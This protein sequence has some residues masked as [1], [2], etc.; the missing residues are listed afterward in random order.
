MQY[1]HTLRFRVFISYTILGCLISLFT[2]VFILL[3]IEALERQFMDSVLIEELNYFIERSDKDPSITQQKSKNWVIYKVENKKIPPNMAFLSDYPAGNYDIEY[4][5]QLYDLGVINRENIFYYILYNDDQFEKLEHKI[6]I[7][8][9]AGCFIILSLTTW[10]G[11]SL[12]KKVLDPIITL[13]SE[14]KKM[15]PNNTSNYLAPNYANDEVGILALE[16]DAFHDRLQSL[17][18]R[19]REFTG[20]ASH[21]LRTPLAVISAA[22]EN[23][24]LQ[25]DL[26]D[27]VQQ[28][29]SRIRRS[30][31]EMSTQLNV[32]LSLSRE[33]EQDQK[34][35]AKTFLYPI[36]EQ[37]IIDYQQLL[38][39]EVKV[40]SDLQA[41]PW[42]KA[43]DAIVA[44]LM[45][46]LIKNAFIFTKTGVITITLNP[47]YFSVTDT[48]CGIAAK[49]INR[50]SDRG[51]R[52]PS[53]QGNGFGLD[54]SK[55]I[56]ERY[57]WQL[58]INSKINQG[59]CVEWFFS[60]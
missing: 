47:T 26:A 29:I 38:V 11:L 49:D 58:N 33:R 5:G 21:E 3:A 56:C 32:L 8:L 48:G 10:Y 1:Q 60:K 34:Q 40:I 55:R 52:G 50:V 54:I 22:S 39:P 14:V 59:T 41:S 53:S 16:F 30:A 28:K 17:I 35:A 25:K 43:P 42:V 57:S 15:D 2:T 18:H 12:S 9:I 20:N 45:G 19:E 24:S 4:N 31:N 7:Y 36:V 46:N 6:I 27:S 23:L 51:F 37:L 44:M 13:A